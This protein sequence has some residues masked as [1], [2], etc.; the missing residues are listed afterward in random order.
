MNTYAH[1]VVGSMIAYALRDSET[2]FTSGAVI[3]GC[4]A[5]DFQPDHLIHPHTTAWCERQLNEKL[6]L[7]E[8]YYSPVCSFSAGILCH[9]VCDYFC[10]AHNTTQA[11]IPSRHRRYEKKLDRYVKKNK[12]KL[13]ALTSKMADAVPFCSDGTMLVRQLKMLRNEYRRQTPSFQTD[14]FYALKGSLLVMVNAA[15]CSNNNRI[16]IGQALAC[17]NLAAS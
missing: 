13:Y 3:C 6:Q 17:E 12:F 5:P 15:R 10:R 7:L 14:L 11:D 2:K 4:I 16:T 9:Y 8:L 1:A